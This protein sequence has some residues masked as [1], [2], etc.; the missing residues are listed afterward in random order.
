MNL[1]WGRPCGKCWVTVLYMEGKKWARERHNLLSEWKFFKCQD[2]HKCQLPEFPSWI[3][4]Q[5]LLALTKALLCTLLPPSSTVESS[6]DAFCKYPS[7][8]WCCLGHTAVPLGYLSFTRFLLWLILSWFYQ[9]ERDAPIHLLFGF[10]LPIASKIPN[11]IIN[12][13]SPHNNPNYVRISVV[14]SKETDLEG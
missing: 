5:N 14:T 13:S 12:V 4:S 1:F 3:R 6:S 9:P 7:L 10:P 8:F 2:T 11:S